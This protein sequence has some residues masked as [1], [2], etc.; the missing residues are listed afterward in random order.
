MSA[1][2]SRPARWLA[3]AATP[4]FAV[5]ALVTSLQ[6]AGSGVMLCSATPV[7]SPLDGMTVM[8]LL[9][10]GFHAAPWLHLSRD[11]RLSSH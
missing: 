8:Y 7:G 4:T 5:M 10:S 2:P 1:V 6:G 11:R 9:M 3:L